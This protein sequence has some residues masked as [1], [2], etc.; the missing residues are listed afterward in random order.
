MNMCSPVKLS[1]ATSKLR[2]VWGLLLQ[3]LAKAEQQIL[4]WSPDTPC[5][6]TEGFGTERTKIQQV[7]EQQHL[8][9]ILPL[10]NNLLLV[11]RVTGE[12]HQVEVGVVQGFGSFYWCPG[13]A[14]A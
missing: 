14:G 13:R 10:K 12:L 8:F 11:T 4:H 5:K 7:L 2:A 9:N 1:D 3:E 6:I